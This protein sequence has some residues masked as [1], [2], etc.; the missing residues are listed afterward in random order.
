M[1]AV[2]KYAIGQRMSELEGHTSISS[3]AFYADEANKHASLEDETAAQLQDLAFQ[4]QVK[5]QKA[6]SRAR[7]WLGY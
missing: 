5:L 7:S 1:S 2:E 3:S 6:A 4:A